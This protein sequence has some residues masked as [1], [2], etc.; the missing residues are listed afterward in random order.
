MVLQRHSD[1]RILPDYAD[2]SL[3]P[4]RMSEDLEVD[5]EL[6]EGQATGSRVTIFA[7]AIALALGAVYY[8]LN[9][10]SPNPAVATQN[11]ATTR[12]GTATSA[13]AAPSANMTP[14][15]N[16]DPGVTTGA[17]PTR[18]L[19]PPANAPTGTEVDRSALG[20]TTR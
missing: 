12:G 17:A 1:D 2:D 4:V 14:S 15:S 20:T 10:T 19:T 13:P 9:A 11:G 7:V 6:T 16:T 18:P 3:R 5:P 8:A